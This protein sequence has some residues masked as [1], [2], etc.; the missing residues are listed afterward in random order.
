MTETA[1]KVIA[2]TRV[3]P[4]TKDGNAYTTGSGNRQTAF[5]ISRSEN[6]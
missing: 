1:L 3:R 2:E 6:G 5:I 4:M